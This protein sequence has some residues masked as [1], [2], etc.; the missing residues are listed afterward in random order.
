[1]KYTKEYFLT[2]SGF[3]SKLPLT[4]GGKVDEWP[5]NK[6]KMVKCPLTSNHPHW[7]N[8]VNT[9]KRTYFVIIDRFGK[10]VY[11]GF[12]Y[13]RRIEKMKENDNLKKLVEIWKGN[14]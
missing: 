14:K 13:R 6:R 12:Q 10:I 3:C 7:S 2:H 5:Y 11:S 1:M 9:P 4:K 8:I